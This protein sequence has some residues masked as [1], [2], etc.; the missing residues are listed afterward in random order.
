MDISFVACILHLAFTI[1]TAV[2]DLALDLGAKIIT[3]IGS[4]SSG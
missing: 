3:Y 2:S 1:E 4:S